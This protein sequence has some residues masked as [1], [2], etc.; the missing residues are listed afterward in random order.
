VS[1]ARPPW[2]IIA[3]VFVSVHRGAF[4]AP[5]N[6]KSTL[7]M[8]DR[9]LTALSRVNGSEFSA[10]ILSMAAHGVF[11]VFSRHYP[12]RQAIF[13]L[14]NVTSTLGCGKSTVDINVVHIYK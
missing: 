10:I 3:L 5:L 2:W 8:A 1:T 14:F 12:W 4:N 7:A 11:D 6:G 9:H 13:A